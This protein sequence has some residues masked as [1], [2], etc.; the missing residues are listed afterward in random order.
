MDVNQKRELRRFSEKYGRTFEPFL[1]IA[2]LVI[3]AIP[4]LT[5]VNLTPE[6]RAQKSNNVL[7]VTDE[8]VL[9]INSV[10]GTHDVVKD[11][12]VKNE[13]DGSKTYSATIKAHEAG[14]VSKPVFEVVN[15]T[16][17][18]K[19]IRALART[20]DS[21]NLKV[22][23]IFNDTNYVLQDVNGEQF[24]HD[25][26]LESG[27]KVTLYLTVESEKNMAFDEVVNLK[28]LTQ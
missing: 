1:V 7:G 16:G 19:T 6:T 5:V 22:G 17:D 11:E 10:G 8:G 21:A 23:V 26:K 13:D 28:L 24:F 15:N 14:R 20:E 12:T 18:A 9:A 25:F 3:F 2:I 4:I 27:Q